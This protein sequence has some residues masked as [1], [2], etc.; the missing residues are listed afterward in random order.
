MLLNPQLIT[1]LFPFIVLNSN[2]SPDSPTA[3]LFSNHF[4]TTNSRSSTP[5]P[6]KLIPTQPYI[7]PDRINL[8][9]DGRSNFHNTKS[10]GPDAIPGGFPFHLRAVISHPL[11]IL[12]SESLDSSVFSFI[13]K[14][15]LQPQN[16]V[17]KHIHP[18]L[19]HRIVDKIHHFLACHSTSIC[20]FIFIRLHL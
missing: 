17:L 7:L 9:I 11:T 6:I 20:N 12:S 16:L 10:I 1:K 15:N 8:D 2:I 3:H 4:T 5:H 13:A 19:N 18:S 14:F